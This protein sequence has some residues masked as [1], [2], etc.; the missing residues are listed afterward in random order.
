VLAGVNADVLRH[1]AS[2]FLAQ[3]RLP[4]AVSLF[5]QATRLAPAD[6]LHFQGLGEALLAG[7][8]LPDAPARTPELLRRAEAAF[9]RARALDPLAPDHTANLARLA[10]RRA[11]LEPDPAASRRQ[12][13]EAARHYAA[14]T[15]LV[16]GNT[17][18]LDETAE[19][20]FQRLGDFAAA[21]RKLL[22]SRALDPTFDYTHAALGDLYA[23]RA[24]AQG[25][26]EDFRRAAAAYQ[27]AAS[28]RRSLKALVSLGVCYQELGETGPAIR[29]LEEA[30]AMA[31]PVSASWAVHERLAAL[32]ATR[33]D[34]ARALLHAGQA[35]AQAP[36]KDRAPLESR[37]RAADLLPVR[38]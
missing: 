12:A 35:L 9:Q 15:A 34:R 28:H 31:P 23:A 19:L 37:L 7:T 4:E 24:R 38:P 1:F 16:P 29:A 2:T 13:E 27:E 33:D 10:R 21:E 8:R 30:L 11:E 6:A 32:Y 26:R 22:K 25:S 17:L 14:A 20:D 18:L 3:G 5:E 36:Q